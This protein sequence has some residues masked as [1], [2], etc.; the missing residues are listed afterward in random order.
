VPRSKVV[1][2]RKRKEGGTELFTV[3]IPRR[4]IREILQSEDIDSLEYV[5]LLFDSKGMSII[6]KLMTEEASGK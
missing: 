2:L 3:T 5:E 1:K 6:I 4:W